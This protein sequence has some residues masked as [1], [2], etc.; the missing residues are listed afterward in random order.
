M[1]STWMKHKNAALLKS[2]SAACEKCE[3]TAVVCKTRIGLINVHIQNNR[4]LELY[5]THQ[6]C[7]YLWCWPSHWECTEAEV[8]EVWII[9]Q[10][11]RRQDF[12]NPNERDQVQE[13][14]YCKGDCFVYCCGNP[15]T[16]QNGAFPELPFFMLQM[17]DT[18]KVLVFLY[19]KPCNKL[20]NTPKLWIQ[21]IEKKIHHAND[22][23]RIQKIKF[24]FRVFLIRWIDIVV[25]KE[26]YYWR[27]FG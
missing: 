23:P 11:F 26:F 17:D 19:K 9:S 12:E 20:K 21:E 4:M 7:E 15:T 2:L 27:V 6:I 5:S 16:I 13:L 22:W 1:T 14:L 24:Q 10:N 25:L 3:Y 18:T 8:W